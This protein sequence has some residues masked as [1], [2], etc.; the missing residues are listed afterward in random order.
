MLALV[1]AFA[2]NARGSTEVGSM[3]EI[4]DDPED[5]RRLDAILSV[6]LRPRWPLPADEEFLLDVSFQTRGVL[7]DLGDRPRKGRKQSK[8]Q[9]AEHLAVWFNENKTR[10][11]QHWD[12]FALELEDEVRRIIAAHGGE[13]VRQ[14][15]EG[16]WAV[17][18]ARVTFPDS[19]SLRIK[20]CGHGFTDLILNHPRIFE[21]QE[22]DETESVEPPAATQHEGPP[23]FQLQPPPDDAPLVCVIDSGMQEG[24]RLLGPA[25][26]AELSVCLLPGC[27][28][29]DVA[30]E[31]RDGGH[32]TRV[33]G[34][35]L[36]P[37]EIPASGNAD[38]RCWLGNAR[39]LNE[40][41]KLP[42]TLFPPAMLERVVGHFAN[43]KIFVQSI[44][45]LTP[46]PTR[47]MS[48]WAAK[49]DEI[50]YT[51]DALFIV[52]AGNLPQRQ[53][54]PG[55][56]ILDHLG[57]GAAHPD[58]LLNDSARV[59]TPAQSLQALTVGSLA[60]GSFDDD[61]W[62]S[63]SAYGSPSCFSRTGLGI[64]DT[65]KPD[66]VEFGGDLCVRKDGLR[67]GAVEKEPTSPQLVRSTLNGGPE[68]SRDR[69]GTSFAAPKVAALA[70][71]LQRLLPDQPALLYR[72]LI[73][74][75]ARWPEW[76][77][78]L[79]QTER[80]NAF[81]WLGYG[82]PD[83]SRA[84]HNDVSRVTLITAKPLTLGAGEAAVFE[85]PIPDS[86]RTPGEENRLRID[87]TLSYATEPRR[88]RASLKGYQAVWLDWLSSRLREPLD[89]FLHR[90]WKEIPKPTEIG[91][92]ESIPW[93]LSDR[94]ATG[95]SRDVRRQG[96][97]Q[98]D[99]VTL[100]GFDLPESFVIAVRGHRGWNGADRTAAA[101][102][103]LAVS[104][105]AENPELR[106]YEPIRVAVEEIEVR[107]QAAVRT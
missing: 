99:W 10:L 82:L 95:Q 1:E 86:L 83:S 14:W 93:M 92:P 71:D 11:Y 51:K 50:S 52:S 13:I 88:T 33:G 100:S 57:D 16:Q 5:P 62:K 47:H 89:L 103:V 41:C 23:P 87:V 90:M 70:A 26:A 48:S 46:A 27:Q 6:K 65:V 36:Y 69:V 29:D 8:E 58:Y 56:G 7:A 43:C 17:T 96:T 25:V 54:V 38:A 49:M 81:R 32:G 84:L 102:F 15:E 34:A 31:V 42:S 74:N 97:L 24:H 94:E 22:P 106:V 66:V 78:A 101:R 19:I 30:D 64:W 80:V 91:D 60:L 4:L 40:Q 53:E 39:V 107:T 59:A 72:A 28:P 35:V 79:A 45:A 55:K 104:I 18:E 12:D 37:G 68:V 67:T 77:E 44:N 75:S 61:D 85:V 20:M 76:A 21:V 63:I 105:E 2:T 9:H 98:K 3:L 73:A